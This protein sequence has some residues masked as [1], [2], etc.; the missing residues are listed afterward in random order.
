MPAEHPNLV[1]VFPDEYR[2]QAMG[3]MNQDPVMTPNLDRFASE[4]LVLPHAVS[5]RPVCSPYRAM[6]LSGKYP[7][8]N[9]VLSNCNSDTVQYGN[10]LKESE[11]CISDVLHDAGYSQGYIGKWHLD[12][13]S[14]QV[15]YTEGRRGD[16]RVWD[17]YTPPGRPR[18][19]FD[20]WYAYGCCDWHFRPH[21]WT[22]DARIDAR[23]DV[24]G[25]SVKHETDVAV[26][27]IRNRDGRFRDADRPFSLFVAHN[28]PHMPFTQV[29][30]EYV[31]RYGDLTHEDLLVRPNVRFDE[32]A[33]AAR[34]HVKSYFAAVTGVDEQ[35]GR[36]LQALEEEGVV[37]D[38][39]VVFTSDHGEMMGSHGLMGKSV[40]YEESFLVPF[41]IRWPDRIRAGEDDLL[42]GTPDVMPTLLRMMG[43]GDGIP[44]GVEG[45]DYSGVLLGED[46]SR[47]RSALYLDTP[48]G[49]PEGG[50]RGVRTHRYTFV[51]ARRRDG[52]ESCVLH[53]NQEDPYQLDNIADDRPDLVGGLTEELNVWLEKTG[54][55]W[56]RA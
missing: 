19:G 41:V 52:S 9:G 2:Q 16:G 15:E 7:H 30:P 32:R 28:P 38:T 55:P 45:C 37:R 35:F 47:P 26:D 6:L 31:E 25:W 27:Y 24:D 34:Q 13:P 18:H 3:F 39:I 29:P 44:E 56:V 21:Y 14:E 43:F 46:V 8:A 10:Y 20:F 50:R 40:W 33:E 22:G 12:A 42:L 54:D 11:R 49:W 36:I 48:P 17:G 1:F 53:D 5:S 23:I 51:T 4:G